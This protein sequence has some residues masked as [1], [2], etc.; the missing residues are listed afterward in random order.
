MDSYTNLSSVIL[1]DLPGVGRSDTLPRKYD[2]E[3]LVKSLY[4]V[5]CHLNLEKAEIVAASYGTP[6]GI[7]FS[8]NYPDLV[9]HLTLIGTM[10]EFSN[11]MREA[12]ELSVELIMNNNMEEYA[13]VFLNTIMN[14]KEKGKISRFDAI[15]RILY[16]TIM[17]LSKDDKIKYVENTKRLLEYK[18]DDF[19]FKCS[20]P[21]LVCTG[22]YDTFTK[23]EYCSEIATFF[24]NS[25]FVT[26]KNAD[27]LC[28]IEQ[29]NYTNNLIT[30]FMLNKSMQNIPG[31]NSN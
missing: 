25:T 15:R 2:L 17:K 26:I 9:S 3:F 22:E 14:C 13:D 16:Y 20:S 1:V 27:H 30:S 29:F 21:V 6:V 28:N 19:D 8:N 10:K 11:Q 31:C 4:K 12:A 23:P 7:L 5:F 24:R 18:G